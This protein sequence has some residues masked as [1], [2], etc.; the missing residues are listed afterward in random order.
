MKD[1]HM[2]VATVAKEGATKL[3]DI[4]RCLYPAL[5]SRIEF[6]KC[7]QR[8]ILILVQK[9]DA[10]SGCEIEGVTGGVN[11]FLFPFLLPLS[12]VTDASAT[13]WAFR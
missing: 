5:S 8:S 2:T 1:E 10:H 12:V 13:F 11:T 6:S 4:G 9:L 3:S 7:L